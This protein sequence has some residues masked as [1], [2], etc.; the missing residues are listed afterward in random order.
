MRTHKSIVVF[1]LL[2]SL[3]CAFTAQGASYY[4]Q[5]NF[6]QKS[7]YGTPG[8]K[9]EEAIGRLVI[10]DWDDTPK[11]FYKEGEKSPMKNQWLCLDI[12]FQGAYLDE[13][14]Y[15][16]DNGIFKANGWTEADGKW[17]YQTVNG[18]YKGWLKK[19]D[20]YYYL[21][22]D[23]LY[24][25]TSGNVERDGQIYTIGSDGIAHPASSLGYSGIITAEGGNSGWAEENGKW[26][27]LQNGE[28]LKSQWLQDG[29]IWYYLGKDG[30]MYYDIKEIDNQVY[31]FSSD[32]HMLVNDVGFYNKQKYQFGADGK[33]VA[34]EMTTEEKIS[35]SDVVKWMETTYAIY[36]MEVE[37]GVMMG[38]SYNV[39]ELLQRDW[40]ISDRASGMATIENLT[41]TGGTTNDKDQ[42]AWNYSR[43]MM[44]CGLLEKAGY[45][46]IT[47][48]LEKQ[49]QIA[50]AIQ[51]SFVSWE[52]F[53]A[54]YM[55]GFRNWA[56]L[57]GRGDTISRRE[58][59]YRHLRERQNNP[60]LL[61]W[62]LE[63]SKDW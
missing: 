56:Y 54:H 47:E 55:N 31:K 50:P 40:G 5:Q 51:N 49:F 22:P 30:Y 26:F 53:N 9:G 48:R 60:F 59:W 45:L 12:Y 23:E 16:F 46:T 35:Q 6:S 14:W 62:K 41:V 61:S 33:G 44:L 24:M 19:G 38:A 63:L 4:Y 28:R 27:F 15:Y 20:T 21:D 2:L 25:W 1:A 32:G 10:N 29:D 7:Y 18:A 34:V 11:Y 52:D 43:A 13:Y 36:S 17:Y 58:T 8:H 39:P 37:A 3:T 42:K 57:V